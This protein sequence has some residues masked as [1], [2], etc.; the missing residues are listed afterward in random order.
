MGR[1]AAVLKTFQA[2][3]LDALSQC[4]LDFA[5][6]QFVFG[7]HERESLAAVLHSAGAADSMDV[8][9]DGVGHVEVDDVRDE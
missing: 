9:I 6:H 1:E 8:G 5:H 2:S 7:Q 4:G 3:P